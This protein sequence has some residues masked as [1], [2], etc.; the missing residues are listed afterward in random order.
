[1]TN[2]VFTTSFNG[3]FIL[4]RYKAAM[5]NSDGLGSAFLD[6]RTPVKLPDALRGEK[7]GK[8]NHKPGCKLCPFNFAFV[9][10]IYP[11]FCQIP[12]GPIDFVNE[13]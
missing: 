8:I 6:V 2:K 10:V 5:A 13:L 12:L 3:N 1:M 11:H 9:H 7:Y 4:F